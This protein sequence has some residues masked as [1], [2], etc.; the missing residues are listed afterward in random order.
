MSVARARGA[1]AAGS[2]RPARAAGSVRAALLLAAAL[3][4]P[5]APACVT[6][7]LSDDDADPGFVSVRVE[8]PHADDGALLLT[9]RAPGAD[10]LRSDHRIYG[11]P[12]PAA[13]F[14]VVVVGRLSSGDVLRFWAPDR[15]SLGD[16]SV[17]VEEAAGRD[18]RLRDADGYRARLSRE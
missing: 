17:R 2:A 14:H 1:G 16:F 6:P 7:L 4:V 3:A 9:L 15:S 11:P 18:Y 8:S 12:G 10:S 5:L 13:T